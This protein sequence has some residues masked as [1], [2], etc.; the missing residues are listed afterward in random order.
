MRIPV[1]TYHANN[2][3]GNQYHTNDLVALK[4]DLKLFDELAVTIISSHTLIKWLDKEINLDESRNYL[5][6]TFDDGTELDL[7]DWQHPYQ[8]FQQSAFT[9]MKEFQKSTGRYIH[10]T[11]FVIASPEARA[12]LETTC[13]AGHKVWGDSWW[14]EAEDSSILSIE[15]HSWDHL[16]HTIEKVYQKDNLKGDFSVIDTQEEAKKQI[17]D[18]SNYI[19]SRIKNKTVSLFAYPYGDYND[20]LTEEFLPAKQNGIVGA[21]TCEAQHTQKNT[22]QWKIPRYVC[23]ADWKNVKDLKQILLS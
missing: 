19:N 1:L 16:H 11:S 14:Q 10:A 9:L 2:I 23:G 4:E 18:A 15:N 3:T 5:V 20:F 22:H 8:G 17:V 6:L 12:I 21:F 13:L 7:W